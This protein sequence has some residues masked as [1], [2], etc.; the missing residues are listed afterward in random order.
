M[1]APG[2]PNNGSE[3][4]PTMG[5]VP[6]PMEEAILGA[7]GDA[8][9]RAILLCLNDAPRT[10]QELVQKCEL[11]QAS[12]YRKLRELQDAG[13]VGVQRSAL[14]PDGHRTDLYRSLVILAKV[15]LSRDRLE[16]T[17]AFRDLAAERL[18]DLWEQVRG[19]KDR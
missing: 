11:P 16:V 13:L 18:G 4:R 6:R 3:R 19:G 7:L 17:A 9:S 5:R 15:E 2:S 8:Q 1:A 10:V 12:A 14:S